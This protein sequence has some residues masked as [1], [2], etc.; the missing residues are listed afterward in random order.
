[1]N[2]RLPIHQLADDSPSAGGVETVTE[3]DDCSAA[4]LFFVAFFAAVFAVVFLAAV[5]FAAVFLAAAFFAGAFLAA[6]LRA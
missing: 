6:A 5:F 2:E 3:G 4:T 1:M